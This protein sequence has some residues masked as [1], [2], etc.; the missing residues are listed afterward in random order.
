MNP[1]I[2]FAFKNFV[3]SRE[4]IFGVK[5]EFS[6]F[7]EDSDFE[8]SKGFISTT[9]FGKIEYLR[10]GVADQSPRFA[11]K[12][13]RD[14]E[15]SIQFYPF[16]SGKNELF[17]YTK[18]LPFFEARR[19]AGHLFPKFYTNLAVSNRNRT[20][21][22][23]VMENV[24]AS[25]FAHFSGGPFLDLDHLSLMMRKA[26]EFHAC[27]YYVRK[28]EP[29][30]FLSMAGVLS[31]VDP[32]FI[33]Y[34]IK[35][36][37]VYFGSAAE[38]LRENPRYASRLNDVDRFFERLKA[39]II[40]SVNRDWADP[41]LVL[42]HGDFLA[43]NFLFKYENGKPVDAKIVDLGNCKPANPGRDILYVLLANADKNTRDKYWDYL[44]D[45]YCKA[46]KEIYPD[47]PSRQ[48]IV[49]GM[50]KYIAP[51]GISIAGMA[52][53]MEGF[54]KGIIDAKTFNPANLEEIRQYRKMVNSVIPQ[55]M[56]QE[57]LERTSI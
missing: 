33:Q 30:S 53:I 37:N 27:S 3:S 20:E 39:K 9:R 15:S 23:T 46:L 26:A 2:E 51:L 44:I 25:G 56:L 38:I 18:I 1:E 43:Q 34:Y 31:D 10:D 6:R 28:V 55:E 19:S 47:A 57:I 40:E 4:D 24:K 36:V 32:L 42:C 12:C 50:A 45:V 11:V 35:Q 54:H 5:C 13:S 21:S 48:C 14:E 16:S 8:V 22:V 52:P 17:F 29:L 49:D 41:S 7:L